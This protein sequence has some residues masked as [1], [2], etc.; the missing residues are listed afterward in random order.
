M[1]KAT[2]KTAAK[3]KAAPKP[4]SAKK[5]AAAPAKAVEALSKSATKPKAAPKPKTAAKPKSSAKPKQEKSIV[6]Q[7]ADAI[8][9]LASD[10]LHDRIVPTIEQIKSLA[11]SALSQDQTKGK[12][13]KKK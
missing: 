12:R 4:K 1:L 9:Q 5:P 3:A 8:S 7:T 11:A 6:K 2:K 13:T 10:I